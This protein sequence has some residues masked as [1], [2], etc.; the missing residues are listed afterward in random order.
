MAR[1]IKLIREGPRDDL[2]A[3]MPPF[4]AK[5]ALSAHV[6]ECVSSDVSKVRKR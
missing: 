3:A 4:E 6:A 1:D 5:N 2:F